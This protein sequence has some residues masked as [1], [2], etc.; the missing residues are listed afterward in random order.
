MD[1]DADQPLLGND[2]EKEP[3]FS[4]VSMMYVQNMDVV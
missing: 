3:R 1:F 2:R 4:D